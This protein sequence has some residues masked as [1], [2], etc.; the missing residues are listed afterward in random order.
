MMTKLVPNNQTALALPQE[1]ALTEQLF[2]TQTNS[3][4]LGRSSGTGE[5]ENHLFITMSLCVYS[6]LQV[7]FVDDSSFQYCHLS[8]V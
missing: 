5:T 8:N 1:A 3:P 7:S 2:A 6:S 4:S